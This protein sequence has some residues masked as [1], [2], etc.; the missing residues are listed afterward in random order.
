MVKNNTTKLALK[1]AGVY[2]LI[3]SIMYLPSLVMGISMLDLNGPINES[4]MTSIALLIS[5]V[6]W[7]IVGLLLTFLNRPKFGKG[8][9]PKEFLTTGIAVGGIIVFAFAISKLPI[10]ITHLVYTLTNSKGMIQMAL[11][12]SLEGIFTLTGTLI[13]LLLGALL[14]FKAKFFAKLVK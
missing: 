4:Q 10:S 2:M 8:A 14:F 3:Q 6:I 11:T 7:I 12:S 9:A 13:Q 1:L 5:F